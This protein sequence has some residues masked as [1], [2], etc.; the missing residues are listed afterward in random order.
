[1]VLVLGAAGCGGKAKEAARKEPGPAEPVARL[2]ALRWEMSDDARTVTLYASGEVPSRGYEQVILAP[3]PAAQ[4]EVREFNFSARPPAEE[5]VRAASRPTEVEAALTFSLRAASRMTGVRVYT[6]EAVLELSLD[7]VMNAKPTPLNE[8]R[9]RLAMVGE[10]PVAYVGQG[11]YTPTG[12]RGFAMKHLTST[13][14]GVKLRVEADAGLEARAV[15]AFDLGWLQIPIVYAVSGGES[16]DAG[17]PGEI[18]SLLR[19]QVALSRVNDRTVATLRGESGEASAFLRD[20]AAGMVEQLRERMN[21]RATV[22]EIVTGAG[23]SYGDMVAAGKACRA[24]GARW[25]ICK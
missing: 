9:A 3:R 10:T 7:P 24:A 13:R 21:T 20:L 14:L 22:V 12:F 8:V 19:L 6:G 18:A 15:G 5:A 2:H 25:V 4:R 17:G 16:F 11:V 23:V 1:V